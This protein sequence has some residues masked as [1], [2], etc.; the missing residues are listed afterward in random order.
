MIDVI[1]TKTRSKKGD[2][3]DTA[4]AEKL[5]NKILERICKDFEGIMVYDDTFYAKLD[6]R[7][8]DASC[9]RE[10]MPNSLIAV[11]DIVIQHCRKIIGPERHIFQDSSQLD[12]EDHN[13]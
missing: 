4:V 10:A 9:F 6:R 11:G 5:R 12:V 1:Y 13:C 7:Y 3:S 2:D 8:I